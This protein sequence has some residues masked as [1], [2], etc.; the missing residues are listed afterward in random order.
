MKKN[1]L[2]NAVIAGIAGVAGIASVANAVN[3]NPDGLGQVLI[4]PYYTVNGGNNTLVS[5]VNTTEFGKAVKVRFVEGRN[6]REVLDFNLYLSQYD[7]WTGAVYALSDTGPAVLS[8]NDTSCTVPNIRTNNTLPINPAS[9]LRY[10]AFRNFQYVTVTGVIANNDAGPNGLDRTREGHL[11]VIEMG[12]VRN[13][14]NGS[15]TAI[16]HVAGVPASCPQVVNAWSSSSNAALAYWSASN[17]TIDVVAPTAANG[18]G[19][20]FGGAALVDFANGTQL[21]YVADAIDGFSV[22]NLHFAPGLTQ[23]S[24]GDARFPTLAGADA[25]VFDNGSLIQTSHTTANAIDAVSAVYMHD[26]I[27]NEYAVI[28]DTSGRPILASE[29]VVTF[30]TKRFYVDRVAPAIVPFQN[31]FATYAPQSGDGPGKA[32]V[33][34]RLSV[35]NREE[36]DGFSDCLDDGSDACVDFSPTLPGTVTTPQLFWEAQVVTFNQPS[37]FDATNA[38][39]GSTLVLG[40]KLAANIDVAQFGFTEGWMKMRFWDTAAA[41]LNAHLSRADIRGDRYTGMPVTG[42]WAE[43]TQ[44]TSVL[45]NFA[46]IWRHKGSRC[47]VP[48]GSVAAAACPSAPVAQSTP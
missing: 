19:G 29:W 4:Y 8:T 39:T 14:T 33:D 26:A 47:V 25:T 20:L 30:P 22:R 41:P 1:A 3:L 46:G 17:G 40:S 21:T 9:G 45:A 5:I 37:S 42:F 23:P 28:S 43:N 18:G 2:T 44:T 32:P 12:I 36:N 35:Y 6:S 34:I 38:I 27:F 11:E 16:T 7:V 31:V 48:S 13:I 10:V 24:L 15:L